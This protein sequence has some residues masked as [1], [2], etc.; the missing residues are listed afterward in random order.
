MKEYNRI[1]SRYLKLK[2][3]VFIGLFLSMSLLYGGKSDITPPSFFGNSIQNIEYDLLGDHKGESEISVIDE[4]TIHIR[5]TFSLDNEV[6]Q[7]D[8]QVAVT[9]G[10]NPT[11]N[12]SPHLTPTDNHIIEQHVF[13]SP[14]LIASDDDQAIILIPDLDIMNNGTPVRWYM[15]MDASRNKLVLGMVNLKLDFI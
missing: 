4:N 6:R 2:S 9:P 10:F 5:I 3:S 12:W 15:D 11:F 8:W 7:N 1:L 13:R 14:A